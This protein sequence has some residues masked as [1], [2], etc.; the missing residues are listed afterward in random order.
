MEV[1]GSCTHSAGRF[2]WDMVIVATDLAS[3]DQEQPQSA[4]VQMVADVITHAVQCPGLDPADVTCTVTEATAQQQPQLGDEKLLS[5]SET[6][7]LTNLSWRS[8]VDVTK[9]L[10]IAVQTFEPVPCDMFSG[11]EEAWLA[12]VR[13]VA[14]NTGDAVGWK[15]FCIVDFCLRDN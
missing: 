3:E 12:V 9:M 5:L 2:E 7:T 13:H 15:W 4:R 14:A 10:R 8:H 1:A 11:V 6:S